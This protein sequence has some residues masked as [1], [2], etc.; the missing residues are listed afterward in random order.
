MTARASPSMAAY[1][2]SAGER[3]REPAKV[4]LHPLG[5]QSGIPE[6]QSQCCWRRKY[7]I[8]RV[9]Q[10]GRK[11][12]QRFISNISTPVLLMS[13]VE[14]G[15]RKSR[16]ASKY[17]G[18]GSIMDSEIL[19]PAK[20]THLL[21]NWNFSGFSMTPAW[22]KSDNRSMVRHQCCSRLESWCI[23]SSTQRSLR[24]KLERMA[25]SRRLYPSPDDRNPCGAHV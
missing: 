20:S 24:S 2:C 12:V 22:P 19:K 18:S 23:M 5:Q 10:S 3:N 25:S 6:G 14:V 17:F 9:D 4:I 15:E 13:V 11:Q 16:M 8:P 1:R 7:P 21:A